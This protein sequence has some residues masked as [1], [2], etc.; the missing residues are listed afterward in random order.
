M[1]RILIISGTHGNEHSAARVGMR[2]ASYYKDLDVDIKIIPWINEQ[3]LFSNTREVSS[4]ASTLD[5]NRGFKE[6]F[7][8]FNEIIETFKASLGDY[9]Y[10]IDIHN[11]PRCGNFCLLDMGR[12]NEII[13]SLCHDAGVA[14]ASR[15]ST[16]GTIKDYVNSQ[17]KIG[18]TYE[19]PGMDTQHSHRDSDAAL[20]DIIRLVHSINKDSIPPYNEPHL[21]ASVHCTQ[22]GFVDLNVE[23]NDYVP[24]G[25][26]LFDIRNSSDEIIETVHNPV[27]CE[28]LILDIEPVFQ[29]KG[30][31][32]I[33]YIK[34]T[35]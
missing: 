14:Y 22:T 16:G 15:Y 34:V 9:D 8:S 31:C 11:S 21:L 3:G 4:N 23:I 24:V 12:N 13:T 30:S 32:C 6:S 18:I 20:K 28:I 2:L 29:R 26:K 27:D 5:L 17:G 25:A 10:V 7:G 33:L 19:F 1:K 35:D